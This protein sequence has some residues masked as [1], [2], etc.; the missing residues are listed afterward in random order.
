MK[1]LLIFTYYFF[2]YKVRFLAGRCNCFL[3]CTFMCRLL[4][5][6]CDNMSKEG[7]G[8]VFCFVFTANAGKCRAT[9]LPCEKENIKEKKGRFLSQVEKHEHGHQS[10]A[11][12]AGDECY[13]FHRNDPGSAWKCF[14]SCV[15]CAGCVIELFSFILTTGGHNPHMSCVI[16]FSLH[17]ICCCEHHQR[18]LTSSWLMDN[19]KIKAPSSKVKL[20]TMQSQ[21]WPL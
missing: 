13:H 7:P 3:A 19:F 5:Q 11:Q 12:F 10:D 15:S 18:H 17:S 1:I 21:G 2:W 14:F 4:Q 20:L 6:Q 8:V 9:C 16:A